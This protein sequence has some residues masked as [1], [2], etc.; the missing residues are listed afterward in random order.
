MKELRTLKNLK[1]GFAIGI[2]R[3]CV[4]IEQLRREAIKW[5]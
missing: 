5:I 4:D 1:L 3:Q 2:G